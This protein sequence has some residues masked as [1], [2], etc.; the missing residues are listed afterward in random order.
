MPKRYEINDEQ[1]RKIEG[2]LPG[3]EGH[4]GVTAQDN[5]LFLNGVGY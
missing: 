1:W 5:R 4:V 3:R 2:F